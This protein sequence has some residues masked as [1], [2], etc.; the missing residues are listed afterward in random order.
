MRLPVEV[1][2]TWVAQ[3]F[4]VIVQMFADTT[5]GIKKIVQ[6]T[7]VWE[8]GGKIHYRDLALWRPHPD[9]FFEGCWVFPN[10]PGQKLLRKMHRHGVTPADFKVFQQ[11]AREALTG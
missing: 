3:A 10:M 5:R 6:V 4:N 8:D 2:A 7:E 11:K 1:A 9:D